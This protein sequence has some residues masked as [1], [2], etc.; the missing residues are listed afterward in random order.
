MRPTLPSLSLFP[1]FLQNLASA[2]VAEGVSAFSC[3]KSWIEGAY[4]LTLRNK[5][6]AAR[7][8]ARH[9]REWILTWPHPLIVRFRFAQSRL[10]VTPRRFFLW[11]KL[12]KM[13]VGALAILDV[14]L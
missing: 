7:F 6:F 9:Y 13:A 10:F 1:R 8:Q 4:T 11:G 2:V 14:V 3:A 5:E 12:W